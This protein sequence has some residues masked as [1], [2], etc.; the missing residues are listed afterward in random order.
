L[1]QI[2]EERKAKR[3]ESSKKY[4]EKN[5]EKIRSKER[6]RYQKNILTSRE[7]AKTRS[8]KW[9][10]KNQE[11]IRTTAKTKYHDNIEKS[12][13]D[14]R[15]R[16]AENPKLYRETQNKRNALHRDELNQRARERRK[17][18][19]VKKKE[20]ERRRKYQE[21]NEDFI[22]ERQKSPEY[23]ETK[24]QYLQKIKFQVFSVYSKR[25]S[26]SKIPCCNCCGEN[27]HIEF[28]SIDHIEGRKHLSKEIKSLTGI[29]IYHYLRK[30]RYPKGYQVLC[31]NCNSA[32]GL[33]GQCPHEKK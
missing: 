19:K 3:R 1:V 25:L 6:E 21:E 7:Q 28:L 27:S 17:D 23:K 9:Y 24:R 26:K 33:F 5:R 30:N 20:A 18:P 31:F 13:S 29:K 16:Y 14:S 32:K 10:D 15:K 8:K 11:Q 22:K 4:R 2:D 12:R